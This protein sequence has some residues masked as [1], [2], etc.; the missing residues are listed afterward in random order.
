MIIRHII[1]DTF[2][3][4][5]ITECF[6]IFALIFPKFSPSPQT[7]FCIDKDLSKIY[8]S[9][10][11]YPHGLPR[12]HS[13]HLRFSGHAHSHCPPVQSPVM[14]SWTL[15]KIAFQNQ[16]SASPN[17]P[18]RHRPASFCSPLSLPISYFYKY[19]HYLASRPLGKPKRLP[20]CSSWS[21]PWIWQLL[22]PLNTSVSLVQWPLQNLLHPL[23]HWNVPECQVSTP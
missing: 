6:N 19:S 20:R 8:F 18:L 10:V 3:Y 5:Y 15:L 2:L 12:K 13:W 7:L 14:G 11:A 1:C 16:T 23:S 21:L 9:F 4:S 17:Q 22:R